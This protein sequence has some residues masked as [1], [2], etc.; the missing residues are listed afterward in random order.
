MKPIIQKI[1]FTEQQQQEINTILEGRT[2]KYTKGR[3]RILERNVMYRLKRYYYGGVCLICGKL[4]QYK[5]I[6]KMNG[7]NLVEHYCQDHFDKI[8]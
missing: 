2:N 1:T 7:I 3:T 8:I 5:V 6:H 4:P